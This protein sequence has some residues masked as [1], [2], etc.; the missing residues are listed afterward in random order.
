MKITDFKYCTACKQHKHRDEYWKNAN[1][2]DGRAHY[3]VDC[4]KKMAARY[5]WRNEVQR[6]A[7][8]GRPAPA[9]PECLKS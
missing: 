2:K 1:S 8:Y 6:A 7:M 5:R 9:M 4:S 3:C